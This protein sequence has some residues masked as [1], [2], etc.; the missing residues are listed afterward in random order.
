MAAKNRDSAILI[1]NDPQSAEDIIKIIARFVRVFANHPIRTLR[2]DRANDRDVIL[3]LTKKYKIKNVPALITRDN[4]VLVG[5]TQIQQFIPKLAAA[6]NGLEQHQSSIVLDEE[7]FRRHQL[8]TSA[9]M[10]QEGGEDEEQITRDQIDKRI[11]Q[12]K[13]AMEKRQA[14]ILGDNTPPQPA[15]ARP[16]AARPPTSKEVIVPQ[17]GTQRARPVEQRPGAEGMRMPEAPRQR[18][19]QGPPPQPSRATAVSEDQFFER[20]MQMNEETPS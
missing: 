3:A 4:S 11:E 19:P 14:H 6:I 13:R 18:P 9:E 8:Q 17:R 12:Y 15:K 2:A 1:I 10:E 20:F 16:D 7:T 5:H